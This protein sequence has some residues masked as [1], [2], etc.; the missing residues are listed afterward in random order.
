MTK[1]LWVAAMDRKDMD[2]RKRVLGEASEW[3]LR[4]QEESISDADIETWSRWMAASP[5]HA[6]AFDDLS[7]LWDVSAGLTS[8][9]M[10]QARHAAAPTPPVTAA[11]AAATPPLSMRRGPRPPRR[12]RAWAVGIAATLAALA[13]GFFA[14]DWMLSTEAVPE[15]APVRI[16]SGAGERLHVRLPDGSTVDLDASSVVV[17]RF[18]AARRDITL[19]QGRAYF[20]VAHDASRPFEVLAN[21]VST[22][23]VGTRFSVSHR[24]HDAVSVAVGEGRVQVRLADGERASPSGAAMVEIGV[25]QQVDA[26]V[27]DGLQAPRRIDA[28]S[29][30]SWR[31][32]SMSYQ[33]ESLA[34]VIEDLNRYSS[35]PIRLQDP[36]L[37]RLL[38]TGRWDSAN[39]DRWV[40]GLARALGLSLVR[41]SDHLLLRAPVARDAG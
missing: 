31:Q 22:R 4:L 7:A 9:M 12:S 17:L 32:G 13:V 33:A 40:E 38:V 29:T 39:V 27:G 10:L 2:D 19:P 20:D 41:E 21:G 15:V 14:K 28:E 26:R 11:P 36:G 1:E 16:A 6:K 5:A 3:W 30:L 37:G 34:N 24:A 25:D 23:A 18:T 8:E 35:L